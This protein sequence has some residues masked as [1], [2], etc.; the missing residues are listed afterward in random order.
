MRPD[1]HADQRI[2]FEGRDP[3]LE[4]ECREQVAAEDREDWQELQQE[5]PAASV[6]PFRKGEQ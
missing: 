2:R 1:E 3:K 4:A 5:E 6:L